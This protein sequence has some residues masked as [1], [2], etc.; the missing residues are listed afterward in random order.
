MRSLSSASSPGIR[1]LT[2]TEGVKLTRGSPNSAFTGGLLGPTLFPS[3]AL[4]DAPYTGEE[5]T[6]ASVAERGRRSQFPLRTRGRS[7]PMM[8]RHASVEK[9]KKKNCTLGCAGGCKKV[10][11]LYGS[12]FPCSAGTLFARILLIMFLLFFSSGWNLSLTVHIK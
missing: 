4:I 10:F 1:S 7:R 5:V 8:A 2:C 3:I 9:G 6:A 11:L 12:W